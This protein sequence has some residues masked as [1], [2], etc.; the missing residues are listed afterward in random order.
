MAEVLT[1]PQ[2]GYYS[3]QD[4]FGRDG[5]FITAPEVSQMFGDL[6]VQIEPA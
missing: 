6:G 2:L 4:P 1:H 3:R 5:D